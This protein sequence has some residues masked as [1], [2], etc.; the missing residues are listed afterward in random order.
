MNPDAAALLAPQLYNAFGKRTAALALS[1]GKERSEALRQADRA[2]TEAMT[3][4]GGDDCREHFRSI[5]SGH[6]SPDRI[7]RLPGNSSS[8]LTDV[9]TFA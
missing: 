8:G 7:R 9:Y 4:A 5:D 1:D 6:Y 3:Q 2:I